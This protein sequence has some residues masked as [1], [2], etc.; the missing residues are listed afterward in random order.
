MFGAVKVSHEICLYLASPGCNRW[1]YYDIWRNEEHGETSMEALYR[2]HRYPDEPDDSDTLS[3]MD[4]PT[5]SGY[6]FG[7]MIWGWLIA[8]MDGEY[9]FFRYI[10][11]FL[12]IMCRCSTMER[13]FCLFSRFAPL[14][15]DFLCHQSNNF[16]PS[17]SE[18]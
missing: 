10:L 6:H 4:A 16:K 7:Q 14:C 17:F 8:P 11:Y 3:I 9:T 15:K 5:D 13:N 2:S 12:L 18:F 1:I